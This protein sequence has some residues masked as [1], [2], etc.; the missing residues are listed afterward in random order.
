MPGGGPFFE[1]SECVCGGAFES[2]AK[3]DNIFV[4]FEGAMIRDES[5]E[6]TCARAAPDGP[7][8]EQR[9]LAFEEAFCVIARGR[10]IV[11]MGE[12]FK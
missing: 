4:F 12:C 9:P 11:G 1:V 8:V 7:K 6:R 3:K 2:D 10:L 5:G